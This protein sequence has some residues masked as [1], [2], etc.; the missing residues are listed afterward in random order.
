MRASVGAC[1]TSGGSCH[2]PGREGRQAREGKWDASRPL[3]N[4]C[5]VPGEDI[6]GCRKLLCRLGPGLAILAG[7]EEP[8]SPRRQKA[9]GGGERND[10]NTAEPGSRIAAPRNGDGGGM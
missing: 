1:T 9:G 3:K 5:S 7:P 4:L 2:R 8:G 6:A 10:E